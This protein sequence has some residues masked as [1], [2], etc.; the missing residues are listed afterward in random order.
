[1]HII[2][3]LIIVTL[4]I[5]SLNI[6]SCV[7]SDT[8]PTEL[9]TKNNIITEHEHDEENQGIELSNGEKWIVDK[10][11]NTHIRIMEKDLLNF[12]KLPNKDYKVL[13]VK[14]QQQID[15]LTSNCTMKGK[16]HDELHKWLLPYM[17]LVTELTEAEN[18]VEAEN[19]YQ[20]IQLSFTTF[21]QYFI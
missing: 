8:K 3:R 16:A 7:N 4:L 21:N 9:Q 10:N 1:M 20:K 14:L 6:I 19:I 18:N 13:S 15:L 17:D 11:M 12:A 2:I 5:S